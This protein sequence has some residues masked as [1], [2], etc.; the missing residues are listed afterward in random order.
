MKQ[1]S[2]VFGVYHPA[3]SLI[4]RLDPRV[5][6]AGTLLYVIT[7][8]FPMNP[9]GLIVSLIFLIMISLLAK[10][11]VSS[12][13]RGIKPLWFIL[14]F[15]AVVNLF[16]TR[17]HVLWKAGPF[18]L[19]REGITMTIYILARLILLVAGSSILMLTTSPGDVADGLEKSLGFLSRIHIPVHEY[20]MMMSIAMHFIPILSEEFE[21]IRRAQMARGADFEE[22]NVLVRAKKTLPVLVPL[23]V[24]ALRRAN[25]LAMAMD[26]RCYQ[27]GQGRSKLH[28]LH[29]K[30]E[31][32]RAYTVLFIYVI[33]MAAAAFLLPR[34][35]H[36]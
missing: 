25:Q 2:L 13:L 7:L 15:T 23:F 28:P 21:R 34:L 24:S 12:L 33:L 19:T 35:V 27:G 18:T 6:L 10:A 8:F 4:H 3:N 30:N 36:F 22:G 9:M 26:A 32:Y 11:D 29:Y 14:L 31:D 1:N 17:G 16:F 5:K 20:A